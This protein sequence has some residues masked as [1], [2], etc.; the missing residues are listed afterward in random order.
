MKKFILSSILGLSIG[1]TLISCRKNLNSISF[2]IANN[3]KQET[4]K[5]KKS[6][7]YE[8]VYKLLN[9]QYISLLSDSGT[10]L[11]FS[12]T[13][14]DSHVTK[15]DAYIDDFEG[16]YKKY[17]NYKYNS[18][19]SAYNDVY[20]WDNNFNEH[21]FF[22]NYSRESHQYMYDD[23]KK[24]I[25]EDDGYS[26]KDKGVYTKSEGNMTKGSKILAT[27]IDLN[28]ADM[29][30]TG[31]HP[32]DSNIDFS[33]DNTKAFYYEH[34][35]NTASEGKKKYVDVTNNVKFDVSNDY[36]S[37]YSSFFTFGRNPNVTSMNSANVFIHYN[38]DEYKDY[39][40][41]SIKIDN[42]YLTIKNKINYCWRLWELL[43]NNYTEEEIESIKKRYEGSY[44]KQEIRIEYKKIECYVD[45]GKLKDNLGYS[46]F[47]YEN[48]MKENSTY[49]FKPFGEDLDSNELYHLLPANG[50]L[51]YLAN[52]KYKY[53]SSYTLEYE[54]VLKEKF[55]KDR[56][57]K[58]EELINRCKNNN[59]LDTFNFE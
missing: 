5:I 39:F 57:N 4:I 29:C 32:Y 12:E 33:F 19:I 42:K 22:G 52:Q 58:K 25:K 41:G 59:I 30:N 50:S 44:L 51:D 23:S 54:T 36:N 9:R 26:F 27:D 20:I 56:D 15:S 6:S 10:C 48:V 34:K 43:D 47:K 14:N 38:K 24:E 16:E 1:L 28:I 2:T 11:P 13:L 55:V 17:D 8:D 49:T 7:T 40:E 18:N 21:L 35:W 53:S 31:L 37:F 46:Y 3:G 45:D